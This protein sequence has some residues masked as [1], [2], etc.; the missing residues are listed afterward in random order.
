[1]LW[2]LIRTPSRRA[3]N[4]HP[5]S[6]F[7]WKNQKRLLWVLIRSAEALP[8]STLNICFY[9]EIRTNIYFETPLMC[10][11][12]FLL[13]HHGKWALFSLLRKIKQMYTVKLLLEVIKNVKSWRK[14]YKFPKITSPLPCWVHSDAT[15]ASNCQPVR[16]LNPDCWYILNAKQCESRSV[17]FFRSQPILI[18]IVCNIGHIRVQQDQG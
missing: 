16:L 15:P 11:Y 6:M 12:A 14:N 3:S 10:T 2:V 18:Y 13:S 9:E 5:Q 8:M 4:G 1:M 7:M 17:G